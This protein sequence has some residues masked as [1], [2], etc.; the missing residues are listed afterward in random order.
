MMG[1]WERDCGD[2]S[3]RVL[4]DLFLRTLYIEHREQRLLIAVFDL[5]FVGRQDADRFKHALGRRL[6]LTPEQILLTATHSHSTPASGYWTY[7]DYLPP[8]ESYLQEVENGLL[9]ASLEARSAA[10]EVSLSAGTGKTSIPMSRR[11][12]T[13]DGIAFAPHPQGVVCDALPV[14]LMKDG[15]D[16]PI[17]CLFSIAAHPSNFI[18]TDISADF[19][20]FAIEELDR[21]LG[22]ECSLFLQGCAGDAK[23]AAAG[24]DSS[25]RWKR[26]D[27][28]MVTETGQILA[29]EVKAVIENGLAPIAADLSVTLTDTRWPLMPPPERAE[30][31]ALAAD[32]DPHRPPCEQAVKKLWARRQLEILDG[33]SQLPTSAS[34]LI[35]GIRLGEGLRM[36]AIEGEPVS[37]HGLNILRNYAKGVTFPLGYSNGE[38]LYLPVTRML[39]EGGYEVESYW[40][41]SYPS[42][43]APGMEEIVSQTLDSFEAQGV[44]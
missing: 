22:S 27:R 10:V 18:T 33:G 41:Y 36:I 42:Q 4:D 39:K 21:F 19:P 28:A 8:N 37:E 38:A 2:G 7:G 13:A 29:R 31:E 1:F 32:L 25:D 5:C 43:L 12:P 20:G 17:A 26:N 16:R 40:E 34:V 9:A 24:R 11:R 44:Y 30:L 15:R 6:D 23:I 14:C 3:G 35:H